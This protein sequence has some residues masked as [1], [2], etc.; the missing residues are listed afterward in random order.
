MTTAPQTLILSVLWLL[1]LLLLLF[2]VTIFIL[3]IINICAG[4]EQCIQR[5]LDS[6]RQLDSFFIQKRFQV[7]SAR[8]DLTGKEVHTFLLSSV[9]CR[10]VQLLNIHHYH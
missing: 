3:I 5:F 10:I 9:S 4:M 7:S 8:P 1:L 6:A 2:S